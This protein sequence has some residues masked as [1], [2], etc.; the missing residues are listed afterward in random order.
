MAEDDINMSFIETHF[1]WKYKTFIWNILLLKN[2]MTRSFQRIT[3]KLHFLVALN[4]P[5]KPNTLVIQSVR[6]S[7]FVTVNQSV[8]PETQK[9]F[10]SLLSCSQRR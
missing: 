8:S 1:P 3:S 2:D 10:R 7:H 4:Q 6:S 9:Y 5:S